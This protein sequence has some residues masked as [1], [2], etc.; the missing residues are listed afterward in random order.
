MDVLGPL[1]KKIS[2]N[3]HV[4]SSIDRYNKLSRAIQVIAI[5][6]RKTAIV[7]VDVWVI[8][9]GNLTHM[10][11]E[12]ELQVGT[13]V[14]V[15]VAVRMS[16]KMMTTTAYHPQTNSQVERFNRKIMVRLQHHVAEHQAEW[17]QYV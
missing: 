5:P 13:K 1:P 14:F 8:S 3:Q 17:D 9:Y 2:G 7:F 15:A 12:N 11:T 6:S 4:I 16:A 10:R